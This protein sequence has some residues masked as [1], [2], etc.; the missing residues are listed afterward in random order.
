MLK[1][2]IRGTK[3]FLL[4]TGI[5]KLF[6]PFKGISKSIDSFSSLT[7][8]VSEVN[9][10]DL[11]IND[12]YS[13]K[14][15][16]SKRFQLHERV[17]KAYNLDSKT[18][19]YME[20]GVAAGASFKWWLNTNKSPQSRFTGFDTFEGLPEDWGTYKKGAM[21]EAIPQ[22]DDK[23]GEFIKGLFQD[24]LLQFINKNPNM[25]GEQ[26]N[27]IHLD[28]DLFT[29]TIFVLTQLYKY[30]KKGDIIFFDEFNVP[31]HE[32]LAYQ[33]FVNSFDIK[34]K[35]LGAVNNFYQVAFVV[36]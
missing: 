11:L 12:F 36:E 15:D 21:S 26:V 5:F 30:L 14:R 34:L 25:F 32:Y 17:A 9:K 29:A 33:I 27:V 6:K 28:A 23:R 10:K 2:S 22:I 20:F 19:N 8:W 7:S 16:H 24:T 18:I 35:P 13:P 3:D 1:N 31:N 4:Y